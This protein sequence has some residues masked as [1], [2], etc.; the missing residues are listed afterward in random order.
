MAD[1]LEDWEQFIEERTELFIGIFMVLGVLFSEY[2]LFSYKDVVRIWHMLLTI[3]PGLI[4]GAIVGGIFSL[5]VQFSLRIALSLLGLAIAIP[6][7]AL[8]IKVIEVI[9]YILNIR[10]K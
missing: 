6:I 5:L 2:L 9:G 8:I 7:F 4:L 3:I 1:F 10:V